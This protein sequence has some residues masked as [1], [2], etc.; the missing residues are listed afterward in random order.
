MPP[1]LVAR[2]QAILQRPR[3]EWLVIQAEQTS[4]GALYRGYAMWLAAIPALATLIGTVVFGRAAIGSAVI[5]AVLSYVLSLGGTYLLG[6][7]VNALAPT[8]AGTQDRVQAQKLAVYGST[9]GWVAGIFG[10]IPALGFLAILGV[11]SLYLYWVG[12]PILMKSPPD[13]SLLYVIAII[14]ATIVVYVII[15]LI[16]GAVI[17]AALFAAL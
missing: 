6:W 11:Y 3:E 5:A 17:G 12:L 13:R 14:V 8:F 4:V 2:A 9:A 1:G 10:A 16:T 15:G 7:I